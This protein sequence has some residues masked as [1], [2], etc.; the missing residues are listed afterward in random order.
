[1]RHAD[2]LR[3]H[4][5]GLPAA[6]LSP[7]GRAR[8]R[9]ARPCDTRPKAVASRQPCPVGPGTS[10]ARRRRLQDVRR[11]TRAVTTSN[12]YQAELKGIMLAMA[13]YMEA[14]WCAPERLEDY[15]R[16]WRV[17]ERYRRILSSAELAG[18]EARKVFYELVD[19]NQQRPSD[20]QASFR[21][22]NPFGQPMEASTCN[23]FKLS[24]SA[25]S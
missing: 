23:P 15:G 14:H 18:P 3:S 19:E 13:R 9:A 22:I 21:S 11:R 2:E 16:W 25:P 12:R 5:R 1:M 4:H 7:V 20:G 17:L 8:P 6:S 10:A 24:T